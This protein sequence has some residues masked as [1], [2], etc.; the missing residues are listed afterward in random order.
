MTVRGWRGEEELTM[1]IGELKKSTPEMLEM[2]V[3]WA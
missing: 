1:G 3:G 2:R